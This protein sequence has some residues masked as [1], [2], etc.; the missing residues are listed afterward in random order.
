MTVMSYTL[1][2]AKY[3]LGLRKAK[4]HDTERELTYLATLA[5]GK[6]C[7]VEVGV[8]EGVASR[9]FCQVMA[10]TGRLYL[11]DPYFL[12]LKLEKLLGFS[13]PE[14]IA[15]QMV[16]DWGQQLE[17]VRLTSVAAAKALPLQGQADLIFVD[18]QHDYES[19]LQDFHT[20]TPMLT[21]QGVMAFHDSCVCTARSDLHLESGPVRLCEEILQGLHGPWRILDRVDSI[22]VIGAT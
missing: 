20:W 19:V 13:F 2:F 21:P 10:K 22:T 3:L 15:K 17:F 16:R 4:T 9:I 18:A 11:I 6:S 1:E 14:Y 12:D 5:Q 7:I 8:Y